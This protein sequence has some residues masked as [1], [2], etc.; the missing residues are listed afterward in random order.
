MQ[1][2]MWDIK[3]KFSKQKSIVSSEF[4]TWARDVGS[5]YKL[6]I[7]N[8]YSQMCKQNNLSS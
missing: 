5:F 6:S 4:K 1:S 7:G 3:L 2:H 8:L